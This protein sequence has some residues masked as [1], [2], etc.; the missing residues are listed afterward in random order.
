MQD[1]LGLNFYDYGARNYDPAIGRW[2][3]IDPKAE[4]MRRHSPYN[5]AFDNPVYFI[6]P[7]GMKPADWIKNNATGKYVWD[8]S[9]TKRSETPQGYSYVGKTDNSIIQDMGWN[10]R[11]NAITTT[12][13]GHISSDS[14]TGGAVSYGVSHVTTVSAT[15]RFTVSANV[16]SSL[17]TSTGELTKEFNGVSINV[18]VSGKATG[19]DNVAVTGVASTNFGGENYSV[20]LQGPNGSQAMVKE[21]GT[22]TAT[23][24]IL[25]PAEK[26]ADEPGVKIFP[27]VN[28]SGNWQN[29]KEDGS[30][31]TPV[32]AFGITPRTYEHIYPASSP[33]VH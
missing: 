15:T 32:S 14:E 17:N 11:G 5:Y 22:T 21:A 19:S 30:G 7:D 29:V 10:F 3:N 33:N 20:G 31:A 23:G 24:S 26:I 9:V 13:M 4:Q 27:S 6:D 18:S 1:E 2:M 28:V 16:S 12:K 25:I 8:N